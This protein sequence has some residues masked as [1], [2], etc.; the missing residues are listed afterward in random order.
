[1]R[2]LPT[3][4]LLAGRFWGGVVNADGDEALALWIECEG[5]ATKITPI[6]HADFGGVAIM[7]DDMAASRTAPRHPGSVIS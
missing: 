2:E 1:M 5:D 7:F 4:F 6:F 3:T